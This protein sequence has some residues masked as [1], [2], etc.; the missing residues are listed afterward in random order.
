MALSDLD[1]QHQAHTWIQRHGDGA[2]A[3]A[4]AMVQEMRRNG[5][6]DGADVWLRLIVALGTLDE[7]ATRARH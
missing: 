6:S 2:M 5:D 7:P 1:V 4:R 3:K